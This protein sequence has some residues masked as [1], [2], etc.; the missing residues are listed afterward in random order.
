MKLEL[1]VVLGA[2]GM[3]VMTGD[4]HAD[5]ISVCSSKPECKYNDVAN[6]AQNEKLNTEVALGEIA[7]WPDGSV[8]HQGQKDAADHCRILGSRLPTVK[9]LVAESQKLGAQSVRDTKHAGVSRE[10]D[11][12]DAEVA[13]MNRD[14]Y[15]PVYAKNN[16]G[17]VVVDFYFNHYGYKRPVGDL[18]RHDFWSSTLHPYDPSSVYVLSGYN[19]GIEAAYR[20]TS[21]ENPRYA[22][23]CVRT[24]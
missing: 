10:S 18:G 7:R 19:G 4:L 11:A 2:V 3:M 23:R 8:I 24:R 9:E 5:S 1:F 16:A 14:G 12:V 21:V 17:Q 22:T 6:Q 15:Y 13:Q 20:N